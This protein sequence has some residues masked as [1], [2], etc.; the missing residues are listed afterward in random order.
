VQALPLLRLLR[1]RFPNGE[2]HWWIAQDLL[3]LLEGDPDLTGLFPFE[4]RGRGAVRRLRSWWMSIRQMRA[5]EFDWVIDLQGLARSGLFAWLANGALTVGLDIRREGARGFYDLSIPRPTERTHAVDWYLAVLRR[6]EVPVHWEF[7]WL[8][9]QARV[10]ARVRERWRLQGERWLII[11][12]GARWANKRWPTGHFAE[13]VRELAKG[14]PE[15]RF[16]IL[17]G[18]ED[19]PL[20]KEICQAAPARCLDLTGR[21]TLPEMIEWVR[22]GELTVTNDTGPMHVAAALGRPVVALFGP[23]DPRQTGPYGQIGQALR[24]PLPCAPCMK[25]TCHYSNPLE[26]LRAI[27]PSLVA[28]EVVRRLN[29]SCNGQRL[30]LRLASRSD[31]PRVSA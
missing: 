7:K 1:S 24:Y 10:A 3:P 9:Q 15:V 29:D 25:A 30:D 8:P 31:P 12:P 2:I 16:A 22:L 18:A 17:G 21:T 4:R 26:C 6:L 13:L 14:L 11:N 5:T 19:Q 20:G 23:T 28:D 27:Q